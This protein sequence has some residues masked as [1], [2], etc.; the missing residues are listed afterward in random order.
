MTVL[1]APSHG[2]RSPLF[3]S[4]ALAFFLLGML[5]AL[6]GVALPVWSG[7]FGLAEGQGG[8]LVALYNA[9]AAIAVLAGVAG[10]PGLSMRPASALVALGAAGLA[11][12]A[13]WGLLLACALVAG[14]GFGVLA[15]AINRRFLAEFGPRGPG[16]VALV[17]GIF[18]LG[19]ILAPL[20]FL[21][22]GS[23]PGPVLWITAVL[24][25]VAM[26]L[27]R[28]EPFRGASP[29]L[30]PLSPR[31]SIIL[32]NFAAVV[33]EAS[34][35]GLGASALVDL[36]APEAQA[37]RLVSAFFATFVAARLG[38]A[39]VTHRLAPDLIFLLGLAGTTACL[40]VAAFVSP[41]WGLVPSGAFIGICF[42]AF[43]VWSSRL[44]GPD[45]RF[46]AAILAAGLTG[47]TLGPLALRPILGAVGV[48]SLFWILSVFGAL[49]TVAVAA[50]LPRLRRLPPP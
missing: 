44:L 24:A 26:A 43:F 48:E 18:G 45:P 4:G 50:L 40:L 39:F 35:I 36:G 3:A 27:S 29:G 33:I 11:L 30:P 13:A 2:L 21:A 7:A 19:A 28:P 49:L 46:G 25:A 47:G 37:A 23:R 12:G 31:L 16:M 38:L 41:A 42:P 15:V 8:T 34:L 6:F 32:L 22:V 5:P 20:L 1:P 9:G 17:N 10:V 14:L